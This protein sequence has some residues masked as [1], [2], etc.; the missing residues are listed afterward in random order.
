MLVPARDKVKVGGVGV[1]LVG[2]GRWEPGAGAL[3]PE[4]KG[5]WEEL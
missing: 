3:R 4:G 5:S 1:R 2:Y